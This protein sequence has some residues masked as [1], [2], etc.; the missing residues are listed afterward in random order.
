MS[1]RINET[2]RWVAAIDDQFGTL[3]TGI[4]SDGN[5]Y[6][7]GG[8]SY[9]SW[10]ENQMTIIHSEMTDDMDAFM[11]H[12]L[13]REACQKQAMKFLTPGE[14]K[15]WH[16]FWLTKTGKKFYVNYATHAVFAETYWGLSER[17]ALAENIQV[18]KISTYGDIENCTTNASTG[19]KRITPRQEKVLM[20][21]GIRNVY[22]LVT[23]DYISIGNE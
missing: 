11:K 2:N 8:P 7:A 21:E 18:T 6:H 16:G 10:N 5:I 15:P 23:D 17:E 14:I 19:Q 12:P 9:M 13:V 1:P 4:V 3:Y 20:E 22:S